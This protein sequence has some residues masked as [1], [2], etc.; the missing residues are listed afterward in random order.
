MNRIGF[1][2]GGTNIAAGLV[3]ENSKIIKRVSEPFKLG[4]TSMELAETVH[5]IA[6]E[7]AGGEKGLANIESVG[8]AVP[9]NLDKKC[10]KVLHAYNLGL[11]NAPLRTDAQSLFDI[12]V[13]LANDANAAALAELCSGAFM[14][15]ETALLIT[16]GTGVGG[17]LILNGRMFNGG[18]GNGV[19]I[20]HSILA[21]G[22]GV[23]CTCGAEGCFEALCAATALKKAGIRSLTEN[24]E[25][26]IYESSSGDANKVDAKLVIDCAKVG[27]KTAME[28]FD[29]YVD[30]LSTALASMVNIFD[31][32]VIA[33]GGGIC[34]AGDFLFEPLRRKTC[35]K[36]FYNGGIARIVPATMGNDA[37]IV[38][39]ANLMKNAQ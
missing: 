10:E 4:V 25:S 16:L 11:V 38:G 33:I 19:E 23:M 6:L 2:I 35:E 28:L 8:I 34:N 9:G 26:L 32:E 31:P 15:C 21:Y 18:L 29:S 24:G 12:P 22:S 3:D 20:G 13:Y 36:A 7:L 5:Q 39:A 30:A 27:D 14:G 1:D 17:G 37:G